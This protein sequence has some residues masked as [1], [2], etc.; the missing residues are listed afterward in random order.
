MKVSLGALVARLEKAD[1]VATP[2]EVLA[3]CRG[4]HAQIRL[5]DALAYCVLDPTLDNVQAAADL[6]K[7]SGEVEVG[8]TCQN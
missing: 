2:Q 4:L 7:I 5:V 1:G 8:D 6:F 3:M